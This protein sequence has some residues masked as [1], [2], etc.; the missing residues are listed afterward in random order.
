MCKIS[1]ET[2]IRANSESMRR[3]SDQHCV[4]SAN[5]EELTVSTRYCGV[6]FTKRITV[7]ELKEAY[8]RSLKIARNG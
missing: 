7:D 3:P 6:K 1:K 5:N 4:S 8:G 2:V